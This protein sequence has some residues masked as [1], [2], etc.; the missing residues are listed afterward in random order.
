V[1]IVGVA[2][3]AR[4]RNLT[5]DLTAA[6]AEPDVYFPYAQRTD[7][8]VEIAILTDGPPVSP[9][10]LQAAISEIDAGLPVY[11]VR[12]LEEPIRQQTYPTRFASALLSAFSLGALVLAALGLYGLVAYV[13][14][15]SRREIAV[16]LA[17]GATQGR[18][19]AVVLRNSL[20]LVVFGVLLGIAGALAAS[21]ALQAVVAQAGTVDAMTIAIVALLLVAVSAVA[22]LLPTR[23][24]VALEPHAA[25]RE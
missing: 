7:A 3:D 23:R 17:L 25:L 12:P 16:R 24:A 11:Q 5:A 22:T 2:A 10:L 14:G 18:V 20:V 8:N 15:L 4:H 6:R 13:A 21:R 19:T 1:E 9:A